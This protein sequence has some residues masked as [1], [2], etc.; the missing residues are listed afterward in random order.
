MSCEKCEKCREH[1]IHKNT[2]PSV[3]AARWACLIIVI[4][5]MA[6][7]R[8]SPATLKYVCVYPTWPECMKP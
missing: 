4:V 5:V 6:M 1:E 7:A 2:T 8:W 3:K